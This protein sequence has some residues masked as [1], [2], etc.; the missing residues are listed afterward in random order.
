VNGF[1]QDVVLGCTIQLSIYEVSIHADNKNCK[2]LKVK[3]PLDFM[4]DAGAQRAILE[5]GTVV[6]ANLQWSPDDADSPAPTRV[7]GDHQRGLNVQ[8]FKRSTYQHVN[9]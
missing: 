8:T 7:R 9:A 1:H 4:D 6:Y 3:I 2:I 5:S